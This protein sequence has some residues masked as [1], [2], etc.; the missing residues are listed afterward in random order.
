MTLHA[1]PLCLAIS[2]AQSRL[3]DWARTTVTRNAEAQ[4][5]YLRT[6]RLAVILTNGKQ[7]RH[8]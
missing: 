5:L 1:C 4:R 8:T 6:A 7:R 2:C 3:D